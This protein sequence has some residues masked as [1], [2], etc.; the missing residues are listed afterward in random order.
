MRA[1]MKTGLPLIERNR[2]REFTNL[3]YDLKI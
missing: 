3:I 2:M 1:K